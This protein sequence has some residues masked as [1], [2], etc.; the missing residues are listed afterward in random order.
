M[1]LR[2][3]PHAVG[4]QFSRTGQDNH[5]PTVSTGPR[6]RSNSSLHQHAA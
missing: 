3:S 4:E 1:Y 6:V 2:A 5:N